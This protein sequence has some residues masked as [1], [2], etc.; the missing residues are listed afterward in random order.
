MIT[1][2]EYSTQPGGVR[3]S[4]AADKKVHER[5]AW[6]LR[7]IEGN[8]LAPVEIM[9]NASHGL[10]GQSYRGVSVDAREVSAFLYADGAT[11][12]GC[13]NLLDAAR[14]AISTGHDGLGVLRLE[15]AA[16]RRYRIAA[17]CTAFDVVASYRRTAEV[18]A[19]FTCPFAYFED[20]TLQIAP[21]YNLTG[22][23]E[24][25][26]GVGLERP[27]MFGSIEGEQGQEHYVDVFNAGDADAPITA[28][29]LGTGIT[30]VDLENVTTGAT[31]SVAG[32]DGTSGLVIS[33]DPYDVRAELADGSD[34]SAYV[35]LF[36]A[37]ADFKLAPGA[38]TL[39]V[40]M[41]STGAAYAG[42]QIE[43]RGRYSTCL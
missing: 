43:W 9:G 22:G 23:K 4:F 3:R 2:I 16:G 31:V 27:Y 20:D 13:Q 40:R 17:K 25:P 8:G 21:V 36:S 26:Q 5:N 39:R 28:R 30:A 6:H 35:S 10:P 7:S 1:A 34:A 18:E 12:A 29:L 32:L 37:L 14:A 42:T 11:P 19:L 38:N 33:T 15:N 41:E 24:W